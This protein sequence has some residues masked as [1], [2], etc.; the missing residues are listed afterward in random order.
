MRPP[1]VGK[2]TPV[3]P[4]RQEGDRSFK[5]LEGETFFRSPGMRA[6]GDGLTPHGRIGCFQA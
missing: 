1:K 3:P 2:D 5:T 4:A 6:S